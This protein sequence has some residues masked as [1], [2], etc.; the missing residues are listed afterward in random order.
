MSQSM[1]TAVEKASLLENFDLEGLFVQ[2]SCQAVCVDDQSR[3]D[4]EPSVPSY[5]SV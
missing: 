4:C 2:V 5:S 3:I 1:Y